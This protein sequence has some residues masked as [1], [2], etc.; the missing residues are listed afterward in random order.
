MHVQTLSEL[1]IV[2][3]NSSSEADI[4]ISMH[5]FC[6]NGVTKADGVTR[7]GPH[8]PFDA[9]ELT[10]T[11]LQCCSFNVQCFSFIH[12]HIYGSVEGNVEISG[13]GV[14]S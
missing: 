12:E 10:I 2:T 9:T 3:F 5:S 1:G 8:L 11:R 13:D 7:C 4:S 14:P 6:H